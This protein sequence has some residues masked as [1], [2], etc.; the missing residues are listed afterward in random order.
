MPH[1][2]LRRQP[3][4][5]FQ[6]PETVWQGSQHTDR[7]VSIGEHKLKAYFCSDPRLDL[8]KRSPTDRPIDAEGGNVF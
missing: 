1:M 3:R 7:H 8:L 6:E 4:D 5:G 2:I